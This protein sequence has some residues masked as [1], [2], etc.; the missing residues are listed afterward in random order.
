MMVLIISPFTCPRVVLDAAWSISVRHV[1]IH[2][3]YRNTESD[4]TRYRQ[5]QC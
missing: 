3:Y 1:A 5:Y 2:A 4:I